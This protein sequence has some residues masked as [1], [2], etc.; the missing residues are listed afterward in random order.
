[1]PRDGSVV[2]LPSWPDGG[3]A[4]G[5][6]A[7]GGEAGGCEAGGFV[8]DGPGAGAWDGFDVVGVWDGAGTLDGT[9]APAGAGCSDGIGG[10]VA[11]AKDSGPVDG[12]PVQATVAVRT[13]ITEAAMASHRRGRLRWSA[14]APFNGERMGIS[15]FWLPPGLV[16]GFGMKGRLPVR[17]DGR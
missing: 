5:C 8:V 1:M 12:R 15:S 10:A 9:G 17:R 3:V 14:E 13:R 4:G 11:W 2:P 6:V 16:V 7:G